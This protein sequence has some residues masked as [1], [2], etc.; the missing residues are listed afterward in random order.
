[1]HP[2]SAIALT[3]LWYFGS[4]VGAAG[5]VGA[6]ARARSRA[7]AWS[8]LAGAVGCVGSAIQAY[9]AFRQLV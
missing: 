9:A 3:V 1:M 5:C 2:T 6:A 8:W 7:W 4:A